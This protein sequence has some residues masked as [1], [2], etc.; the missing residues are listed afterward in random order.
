MD[1]KVIMGVAAVAG[2]GLLLYMRKNGDQATIS[3]AAS[4]VGASSVPWSSTPIVIQTN[5]KPLTVADGV[6]ASPAPPPPAVAAAPVA[7]GATW[8]GTTGAASGGTFTGIKDGRRTYSDGSSSAL[9]E[10]E[11]YLYRSGA[12]GPV[13]PAPAP[14][15]TGGA[16][17][18]GSSGR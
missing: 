4:L 6:A 3:G 12:Y 1:R 13:A 18:G 9:T 14:A 2:I 15:P 8:G 17:W 5:T 10:G 11:L 16:A 7:S